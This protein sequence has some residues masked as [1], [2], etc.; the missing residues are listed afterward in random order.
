M[1]DLFYLLYSD[2]T[3]ACNGGGHG[4]DNLALQMQVSVDFPK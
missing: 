4:Y 1:L 3:S 2:V